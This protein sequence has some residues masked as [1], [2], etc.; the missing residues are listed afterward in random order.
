MGYFTVNEQLA[1]GV[2]LSRYN[3]SADGKLKV[4]FDA[5][6]AHKPRV[7]FAG[8]RTGISW[9]YQ[10]AWFRYHFSEAR[11]VG[12]L[13]LPYHVVF[14][15]EDPAAQMDNF[16]RIV[17]EDGLAGSRLVLDMELVH[18][19]NK[20]KITRCLTECLKLLFRRTGRLPVVYSRGMWVDEH[21]AL[22]DLPELDWWLAQYRSARKFPLFTPEYASPPRLPRG[23][24]GWLIH[25]TAEKAPAIGTAGCYYMDYDRWNGGEEVVRRYFGLVERVKCP[26]DGD[27][28]PVKYA[29]MDE[30]A[31]ALH[32]MEYR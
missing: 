26:V 24:K 4:D 32:L 23:A 20:A 8:M 15:A 28:C 16:L 30:Q 11:R 21:L 31:V 3:T 14:P 1:F 19:C 6:A 7:V 29:E 12:I 10:D 5:L 2:D 18:G 27:E 13:C 25:Q 22:A 17:G 9:G